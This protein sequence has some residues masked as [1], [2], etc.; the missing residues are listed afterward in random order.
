MIE[1]AFCRIDWLLLCLL[2]NV[3]KYLGR[4]HR[5]AAVGRRITKHVCYE[6]SREHYGEV[7]ETTSGGSY[8]RQIIARDRH[9]KAVFWNAMF[10]IRNESFVLAV[11]ITDQEA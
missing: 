1:I 11:G 4:I 3:I 9:L 2:C 6:G 5:C 8:S 7:V 10:Q